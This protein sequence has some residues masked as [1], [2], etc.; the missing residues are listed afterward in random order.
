[1]KKLTALILSACLCVPAVCSLASCDSSDD[2]RPN[3]FVEKIPE[4]PDSPTEGLQYQLNEDGTAYIFT[5]MDNCM[6]AN[7]RIADEYNGL[8]VVKISETAF[9]FRHGGM[10]SITIGANITEIYNDEYTDEFPS[11]KAI[12]VADGNTAYKAVDGSLF[13]ADGS[14]LI[15]YATDCDATSYSIPDTVVKIQDN[16]FN[17]ADNLASV[18]IPEGVQIIGKSAFVNCERLN[19]LNLP[20]TV[21]T[22]ELPATKNSNVSEISVAEGNTVYK[23]VEGVLYTKDGK[24]LLEYPVAKE[25]ELLTVP[26]G[27]EIVRTDSFSWCEGLK[28]IV[29][30]MTVTTIQNSAFSHCTGLESVELT[31]GIEIIESGA[32][33]NCTELQSIK[34]AFS[35][36]KV[37]DN[38]FSGCTKLSQIIYDSDK[39]M[40]EAMSKSYGLNDIPLKKVVCT[41]GEIIYN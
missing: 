2:E 19:A 22:I 9:N 21:T 37:E 32:F 7:I 33:N 30:P 34:L 40:W 13:T 8:P 26:Q 39:E 27:V 11:L 10:L 28:S 35:L 12:F 41:D 23:S 25:M 16:A 38:A 36:Y 24:E 18:T 17:E 4:M 15:K 20:A 14:V 31:F 5:G 6:E 3:G 1:M 29:L